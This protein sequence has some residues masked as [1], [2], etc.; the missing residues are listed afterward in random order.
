[1][2]GHKCSPGLVTN[3]GQYPSANGAQAE[4]MLSTGPLCRKA[5]DLWPLLR[6]LAGDPLPA[7]LEADPAAV[8]LAGMKVVL[9]DRPGFA[10]PQES[11]VAAVARAGAALGA[12]GAQAS[13]ARIAGLRKG[14]VLWGNRLG[15]GN[16]HSFHELLG[17]EGAPPRLLGEVWRLMRG[18]SKHTAPAIGLA[19]VEKFPLGDPADG[20]R[21][22]DVLREEI[23]S[24]LGP[25]GVLIQPTFPRVAPRHGAPLYRFWEAGYTGVYNALGLPVTQ[26]PTGLD[27][28]GLPTG[29]QVVGAPGDDVRTVAVALALEEALGGWVPPWT[30]AR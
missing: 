27:A 19:L 16:V 29:V 26:V 10:A 11:Q 3:A 25:N 30:V 1:M 22:L 7:A 18:Q 17:G 24:L 4:G 14:F 9:V 23:L 28:Q 12:R 15:A 2:F 8:S 20:L 13:S 21:Q 6:I 5:A